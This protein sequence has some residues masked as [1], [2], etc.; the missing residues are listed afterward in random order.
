VGF[1][2]TDETYFFKSLDTGE[3]GAVFHRCQESARRRGLYS[4]PIE[5]GIPMK[6]V[7]LIEIRIYKHV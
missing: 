4:T 2:V 3:N 5:F 6:L 1:D 7:R